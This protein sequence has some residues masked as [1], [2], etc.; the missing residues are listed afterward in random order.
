MS[1]WLTEACIVQS[2]YSNIITTPLH[3][4]HYQVLESALTMTELVNFIHSGESHLWL[5][6][7]KSGFDAHGN[8]TRAVIC[9]GGWVYW[10]DFL[11]WC[12]FICRPKATR[13]CHEERFTASL[14]YTSNG[15]GGTSF[16]SV[17]FCWAIGV[18]WGTH[19]RNPCPSSFS[20][21]RNTPQG[22]HSLWSQ[23]LEGAPSGGGLSGDAAVAL[24]SFSELPWTEGSI[25]ITTGSTLSS[26][27]SGSGT[28][29]ESRPC[30]LIIDRKLLSTFSPDAR[31]DRSRARPS[32]LKNTLFGFGSPLEPRLDDK[33]L[34]INRELNEKRVIPSFLS[35]TLFTT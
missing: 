24:A 17:Y 9:T 29:W 21:S 15:E 8:V 16:N 2:S 1:S 33:Q 20:R 19:T 4:L 5:W 32:E 18:N 28:S 14:P 27:A 6:W 35:Y 31:R 26:C 11:R 23:S 13:M 3:P 25:S 12:V 34:E 30:F 7:L 22:A 10:N